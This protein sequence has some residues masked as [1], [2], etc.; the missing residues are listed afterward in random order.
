[1]Q[2]FMALC[3]NH[4]GGFNSLRDGDLYATGGEAAVCCAVPG[5]AT[6]LALTL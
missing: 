1:M 6:Q 2:H 3:A 4:C 5:T